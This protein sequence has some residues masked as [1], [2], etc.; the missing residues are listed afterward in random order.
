MS[1][2][3]DYIYTSCKDNI[4]KAWQFKE[5]SHDQLADMKNQD[6]ILEDKTLEELE[7][8]YGKYRAD[9]ASYLLGHTAQVNSI[10]PLKDKYNSIFTGGIDKSLKLFVSMP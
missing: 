6:D 5:L 8:E 9:V 3:E 1:S 4:V 2:D 10:C 7:H